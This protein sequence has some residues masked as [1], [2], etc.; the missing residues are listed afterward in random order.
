MQVIESGAGR[1]TCRAR[2]GDHV[3]DMSLVGAVEPGN[4]VMV[5]LGAA[6]E[7]LTEEAARQSADAIEALEMAMRGEGGFEHLFGDLID[8][9]PELPDFLRPKPTLES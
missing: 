2:D 8:R 3:V 7:T 4:W 5:F 1:A 6:R 9:E